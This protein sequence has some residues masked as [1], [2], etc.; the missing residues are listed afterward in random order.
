MQNDCKIYVP[1]VSLADYFS[2]NRY[3]NR[4]SFIYAGFATYNAGAALPDKD[5]TNTYD[6]VWYANKED[7][8]AQTNPITQ[9]TGGE[10]YCRYS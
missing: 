4:D 8:D 1:Y 7:L 6:V 2:A 5:T 3:P 10:I 9:G